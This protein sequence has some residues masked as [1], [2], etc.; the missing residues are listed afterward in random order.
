MKQ[1]LN[2]CDLSIGG[3]KITYVPNDLVYDQDPITIDI[4]LKKKVFDSLK[5][6]DVLTVAV[7]GR[8]SIPD[9]DINFRIDEES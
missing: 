1:N 9:L 2:E 7:R 6:G 8:K 5:S 4:P 3:E